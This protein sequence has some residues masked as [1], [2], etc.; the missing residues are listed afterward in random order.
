MNDI[1][2]KIDNDQI[3]INIFKFVLKFKFLSLKISVI[4]KLKVREIY[5]VEK[6]FKCSHPY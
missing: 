5:S 3:S 2:F 6:F 4:T 1:K